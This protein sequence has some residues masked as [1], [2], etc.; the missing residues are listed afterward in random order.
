MANKKKETAEVTKEVPVKETKKEK[1]VEKAFAY[2]ASDLAQAHQ[3][4][5]ASYEIVVTA[6][7]V[8]GKENATVEEAAKIINNFKNKEVK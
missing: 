6:L 4:F 2:S 8:A 7:K 1:N 5:N 3:M